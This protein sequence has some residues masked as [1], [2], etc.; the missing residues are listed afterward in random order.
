MYL[1]IDLTHLDVLH[2]VLLDVVLKVFA[3]EGCLGALSQLGVRDE[4][5]QQ[6]RHVGQDACLRE[7]RRRD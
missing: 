1:S 3:V 4:D 6:P 5:G 2:K 7:R